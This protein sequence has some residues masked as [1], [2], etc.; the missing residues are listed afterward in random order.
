MKLIGRERG[1]PAVGLQR[2]PSLMEG[3]LVDNLRSKAFSCAS[4]AKNSIHRAAL[5]DGDRKLDTD[6]LSMAAWKLR[7]FFVVFPIFSL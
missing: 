1:K 6:T 4:T 2:F 5:A 3:T 7:R